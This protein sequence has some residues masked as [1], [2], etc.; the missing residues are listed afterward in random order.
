M[1]KEGKFAK[2]ILLKILF[3]KSDDEAVLYLKKLM[4][5]FMNGP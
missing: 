2:M 1:G 4:T 3:C 5:S